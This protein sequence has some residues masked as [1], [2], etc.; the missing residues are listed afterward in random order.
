MGALL[1]IAF[2][3]FI[4]ALPFTIALAVANGLDVGDERD[5]HIA[6]G[7]EVSWRQAAV[8]IVVDVSK[9]V[10]PVLIGFGFSLSPGVVSIAGLAAVVGQMWPPVRGHGER[11]N[12]TAVGAL[13]ALALVYEIQAIMLSLIL[14]ALGFVLWLVTMASSVPDRQSSDHLSFR[15]VPLIMLAGFFVAPLL[16]WL[17]EAPHEMTVGLVL[18]LCA[19]A[20][21]RLTAGLSLDLTV[22]VRP[23]RLLLRRLLFDQPVTRNRL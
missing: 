12:A 20:V 14:F 4:G 5:L 17:A 22:G 16:A 8:A 18:I 11:G 15:M 1:L 9:G 13:I 3:Y 6:L 10:F 2:G 23:E 21:K 19:I 7:R